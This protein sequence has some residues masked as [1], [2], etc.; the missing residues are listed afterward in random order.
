MRMKL[1]AAQDKSRD[2]LTILLGQAL[3]GVGV[4][5]LTMIHGVI[6]L[7]D[8]IFVLWNDVNF[9]GFNIVRGI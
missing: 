1:G 8:I 6:D 9:G 3:I 2:I 4:H 7:I 5:G